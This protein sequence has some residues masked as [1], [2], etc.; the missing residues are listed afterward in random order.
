MCT[1]GSGSAQALGE[2]GS[3]KVPVPAAPKSCVLLIAL[4]KTVMGEKMSTSPPSLGVEALLGEQ[5]S[6]DETHSHDVGQPQLPGA[7][8]RSEGFCPSCFTVP[9]PCV[10]LTTT[11]DSYW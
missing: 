2:D 11:P 10:L 4:L 8:G 6:P 7:D 5:L 1:E 9:V 3:Q